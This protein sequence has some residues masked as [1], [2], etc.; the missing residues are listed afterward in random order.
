MLQNYEQTYEQRNFS[1]NPITN[2]NW[3]QIAKEKNIDIRNYERLK[4]WKT[5]NDSII[6]FQPSKIMSMPGS[7]PF[8]GLDENQNIFCLF[9]GISGNSVFVDSNDKPLIL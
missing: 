9:S 1:E 2:S 5:D 7:Y 3:R 8:G 4:L 6:N